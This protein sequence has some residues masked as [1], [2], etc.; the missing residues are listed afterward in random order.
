MIVPQSF[1]KEDFIQIKKAKYIVVCIWP[2]SFN[3]MFY[4]EVCI[5]NFMDTI[6]YTFLNL[7][8]CYLVV[9]TLATIKPLCYVSTGITYDKSCNSCN[10][11]Y[12]YKKLKNKLIIKTKIRSK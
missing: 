2:L 1:E 10:W 3:I 7:I 6:I 9:K 11:I 5:K 4:N 8:I 12:T